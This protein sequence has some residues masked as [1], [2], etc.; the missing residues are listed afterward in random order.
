MGNRAIAT[1]SLAA[2]RLY[3]CTDSRAER[4]D[5]AD[6]VDAAYSGGVDIIQL[7]D[8]KIEAAEELELLTVLREAAERHGKLWAV[9]DRADIAR[10]SGSPVL[11]VGQKDLPL[12][13]ARSLLNDDVLL[14]L[15]SHAPEQVDAALA[16][17]ARGETDYFCAGPLW[18]TPT[19][20]G[21]A[22][23]GLDLVRYAD[24]T[25]TSVPWFAIGG[26]DHS[27]VAQVV[28]AG[29]RRVVVVRAVTEA[30]DPADAARRLLAE[31]PDA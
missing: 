7:R 10:L 17:A 2:A 27:N 11:H 8:K 1:P 13:A 28:E 25:G 4:G 5:F 16:A 21:R 20:P 26:I 29:A 24:S 12:P 31:L 23:V 3:V 18:A 9:N 30:S 15:S 14:G 6:F 19:K 22:G